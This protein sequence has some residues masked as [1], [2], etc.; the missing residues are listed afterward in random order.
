MEKIIQTRGSF[1][2]LERDGRRFLIDN[3][4]LVPKSYFWFAF[5]KQ[6]TADM[7]EIDPNDTRFEIQHSNTG[8]M[9]FVIISQSIVR[10]ASNVLED[11]FIQVGYSNQIIFKLFMVLVALVV[12]YLI[13]ILTFQSENK[14]FEVF[15]TNHPKRFSVTLATDGKRNF[16]LGPVFVSLT[17]GSLAWYLLGEDTVLILVG[18]FSFLS[19]VFT[20]KILPIA[21]A[22]QYHKLTIEEIRPTVHSEIQKIR[23]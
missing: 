19:Y 8:T 20:W 11:L 6:L 16:G 9:T 4:T 22:Y 5:K 15:L 17:I 13:Y 12:S 7:Y 3:R 21:M 2:F 23:G 14:N 10:L 18:L 1:H